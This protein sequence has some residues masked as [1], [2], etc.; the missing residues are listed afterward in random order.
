L[1]SDVHPFDGEGLLAAEQASKLL[2]LMCHA[3]S[4]SGA[5]ASP[6]HAEICKVRV[7]SIQLLKA[8]LFL[9]TYSLFTRTKCNLTYLPHRALST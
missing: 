1:R 4:C 7:Y 3:R 5:H 8:E 2:V 9:F 6:K